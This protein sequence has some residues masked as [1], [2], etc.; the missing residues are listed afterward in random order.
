[1]NRPH[2]T[3]L[4]DWTAFLAFRNDIGIYWPWDNERL[5]RMLFDAFQ[6]GQ[7]HELQKQI[8]RVKASKS[9]PSNP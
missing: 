8:T 5:E 9:E 7:L 3:S 2:A 6:L 4:E 1:M